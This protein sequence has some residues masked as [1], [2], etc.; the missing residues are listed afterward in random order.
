MD[1]QSVGC[2]LGRPDRCGPT[3]CLSFRPILHLFPSDKPDC[4]TCSHHYLI[5]CFT[6]TD[7]PAFGFR[8]AMGGRNT[9]Q[10]TWVGVPTALFEYR[11]LASVC[12]SGLS[13]LSVLLLSLFGS[14]EVNAGGPCYIMFSQRRISF[15]LATTIN[16]MRMP[17]PIYSARTIKVSDGLRRV[18]IS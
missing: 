16:S 6:D 7:I 15:R 1:F 18:I 4:D 5:W 9:E 13:C 8:L 2:V 10:G 11:R 17:N 14:K 12:S 3:D